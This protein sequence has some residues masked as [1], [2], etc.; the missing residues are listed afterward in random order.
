MIFSVIIIIVSK[1]MWQGQN[2]VTKI[3]SPK[4]VSPIFFVLNW[5]KPL[6]YGEKEFS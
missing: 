6:E 3:V 1:L 2:R 5:I 4:N